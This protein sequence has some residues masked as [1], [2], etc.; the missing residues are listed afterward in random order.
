[1]GVN[2]GIGTGSTT[3]GAQRPTSLSSIPYVVDR[4]EDGNDQ[5][6]YKPIMKTYRPVSIANIPF[7]DSNSKEVC[8]DNPDDQVLIATTIINS[9]DQC[10]VTTVT[11][12]EA[13][14]SGIINNLITTTA[15][16]T[17]D[18]KA[19]SN[20]NHQHTI[21]AS[22]N[23]NTTKCDTNPDITSVTTDSPSAITNCDEAHL[24]NR[25]HLNSH[26]TL[27]TADTVNNDS[28]SNTTLQ[29]QS[30]NGGGSVVSDSHRL[31][32]TFF[33][34][35]SPTQPANITIRM[36][37]DQQGRFGFNV[38]GGKDQHLPVL[39]SRVAPNTPADTAVPKLN[40]GDQ[41]L[42]VNGKDVANL[43]HDEVVSLIRLTKTTEPSEQLTLVVLPN[44]YARSTSSH[45]DSNSTNGNEVVCG[46]VIGQNNTTVSAGETVGCDATSRKS[47]I[48][49][50]S[51]WNANAEEDGEPA[52]EYIPVDA[53]PVSLF[54]QGY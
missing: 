23:V 16:N 51:N 29:T 44:I 24:S 34:D 12:K 20:A 2:D 5:E 8:Q 49:Y 30:F 42:S 32:M 26:V 40:E 54:F 48:S 1:M 21:T 6:P 28:A 41:V 53:S 4:N 38:K 45:M 10:P 17:S 27:T 50:N 25:D 13:K 15:S 3:T 39:V 37:T 19:T 11:M 33:T 47:N 36:K 7:I 46:N 18:N 22:S 43:S 52:F 14:Q 31:R 35:E 9:S